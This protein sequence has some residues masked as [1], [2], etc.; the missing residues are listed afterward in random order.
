MGGSRFCCSGNRPLTGYLEGE[1]EI[2]G[3]KVMHKLEI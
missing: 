3:K 2:D 1:G